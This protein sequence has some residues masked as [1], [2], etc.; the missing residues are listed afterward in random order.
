M[1]I[2]TIEELHEHLQWAIEVEH[3]TLAPYL[4]ALYSI[5][6]GHNTEIAEIIASVFMEEML[7]MTLVANVLNATGGSP[8]LDS[9]RLMPSFPAYLP[10]SDKSF[11]ISLEKLSPAAIETFMKIERPAPHDG[12]PED[13]SYETI[14]QF[15]E[16]IEAGI[17]R[18]CD[19]LGEDEVF[20][21]PPARQITQE[22]Y[23]GGAG[24]IITVTDRSS[25]LA[26]LE[27]VIEQGEGLQH[28]EVWDGDRNMFHPERPEVA[29]Y[30]RFDEIRQGR[31]YQAGDTPQSGP[32]GDELH[33]DWDAVHNARPNPRAHDHPEGSEARRRLEEFNHSYSGMLHLLHRAFNGNPKLLAIA[34]GAMYGMKEQARELMEM[35]S[36]D[37]ETTVGI[38]F[39]YVPPEERF[40]AGHD[41]WIAVVPGGPYLV[42]GDVP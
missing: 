34:T 42:Y 7:H 33:V 8:V 18:L 15:Y 35:P 38:G 28:E 21:G 3:T 36:G 23:Y 16:S 22:L 12:L 39:E 37:G 24:E 11:E 19:E 4:S 17:N 40:S 32:T 9:P 27:E 31:S 29:H 20:S 30:F 10:H 13:D 14:G 2:K 41:R 25:A 1:P 26:A 5:E 6:E